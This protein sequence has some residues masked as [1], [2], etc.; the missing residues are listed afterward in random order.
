MTLDLKTS[1]EV[2]NVQVKTSEVP[3]KIGTDEFFKELGVQLS[4]DKVWRSGSTLAK[5]LGVDQK[6]IEAWLDKKQEICRKPGNSDGIFYYALKSR[7]DK[8]NEQVVKPDTSVQPE[9]RYA[10]AQL[11]LLENNL[12][13]VLKRYA[14]KISQRDEEAYSQLTKALKHLEAGTALFAKT[15]KADIKHLS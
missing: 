6:E 4:Q 10:L 15:T 11:H 5:K 7:I 9:E 12:G 3:G 1:A 2:V 8:N 14:L 13:D